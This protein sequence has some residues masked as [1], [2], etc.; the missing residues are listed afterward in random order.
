[1]NTADIKAFAIAKYKELRDQ[2][3]LEEDNWFTFSD[4]WDVNIYFNEW[5]ED[6]VQVTVYP[7]IDGLID[8]SNDIY[9]FKFPRGESKKSRLPA[10][11]QAFRELAR[12]IEAFDNDDPWKI[13]YESI[14]RTLEELADQFP[15][16]IQSMRGL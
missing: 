1:M 7:V 12:V 3:N 5:D 11:Q 8:S 9:H 4:D 6:F 10:V 14:S 16:E 15:E 13:N 2:D